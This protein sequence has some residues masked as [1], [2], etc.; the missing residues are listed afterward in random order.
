MQATRPEGTLAVRAAGTRTRQRVPPA[1]ERQISDDDGDGAIDYAVAVE[2]SM[3]NCIVSDRAVA[4]A[5][6]PRKR[7]RRKDVRRPENQVEITERD[8]VILAIKAT[9]D[10]VTKLRNRYE[11]AAARELDV[12]RTLIATGRRERALLVLRRMKVQERAVLNAETCLSRL[13][14]MLLLI[15]TAELEQQTLLQIQKSTALVKRLNE[16][17]DLHSVEDLLLE[18]QE[19]AEH[20][21]SIE[22]ALQ[23]EVTPD[24]EANAQRALLELYQEQELAAFT[25]NRVLQQ[26][27]V[28][29]RLAAQDERELTPDTRLSGPAQEMRHPSRERNASPEQSAPTSRSLARDSALHLER[30]ANIEAKETACVT[31]KMRTPA[32]PSNSL[33]NAD[34]RAELATPARDEEHIAEAA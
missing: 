26:P 4:D 1:Q 22:Q 9:R 2:L 8:E 20:A 32:G 28:T 12:A 23:G 27:L 17:I 31:G 11:E 7:A 21:R 30:V 5:V 3:G 15:E 13:E 16:H 29:N 24:V 19:A 10:R 18:T 14:E 25:T 34:A 6:I 33:T